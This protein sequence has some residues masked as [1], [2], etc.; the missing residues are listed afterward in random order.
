MEEI[1]HTKYGPPEEL[2]LKT[3]KKLTKVEGC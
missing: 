1:F 2:Q 3:L